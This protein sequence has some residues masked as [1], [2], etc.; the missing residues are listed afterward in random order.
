M[1]FLGDLGVHTS[2]RF[3]PRAAQD[4][5]TYS[6]IAVNEERYRFLSLLGGLPARLTAAEVAWVLNCQTHDLPI[7]VTARLLRPL[8][9]PEPNSV[10]YFC[11]AEVVELAKDRAWLGKVTNTV[12]QHWRRRNLQK[13]SAMLFV[14]PDGHLPLVDG[15]N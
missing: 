9:S 15:R 13:K 14:P 11:A 7:L 4:R 2:L 10:K 12:G 1:V 5:L 8:G 3:S 6:A